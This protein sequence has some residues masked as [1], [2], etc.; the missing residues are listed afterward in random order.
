MDNKI[1]NGPDKAAISSALFEPSD[2]N[3]VFYLHFLFETGMRRK[4]L[5][6]SVERVEDGS[7]ENF[8]INGHQTLMARVKVSYRTDT[9]RGTWT[10]I[11]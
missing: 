2:D 5:V 6:S 8:I 9:H 4:M 1:V 10:E 7:G 3:G 11:D